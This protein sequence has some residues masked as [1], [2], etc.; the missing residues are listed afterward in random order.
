[1]L[2]R[3]RLTEE[4][5]NSIFKL[6]DVF[7][8][9]NVEETTMQY[10]NNLESNIVETMCQVELHLPLTMQVLSFHL[11]H[12]ICE[13]LRSYGTVSSMWMAYLER[14]NKHVSGL[15]RNRRFPEQSIASSYE[16]MD[17]ASFVLTS[18]DTKRDMIY[19][20]LQEMDAEINSEVS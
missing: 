11:L 12:H 2:L 3:G 7:Q 6:V 1:M 9:L 10:I 14:Y 20:A 19:N 17:F 18:K 4:I 16:L 13:S 5:R 8:Q 15:I